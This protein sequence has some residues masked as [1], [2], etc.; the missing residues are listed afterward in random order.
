MLDMIANRKHHGTKLMS[1][2]S[3]AWRVSFGDSRPDIQ[4]VLG[5]LYG[6]VEKKRPTL[7]LT[8]ILY[9]RTLF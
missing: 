8:S 1:D 3:D 2:A 5:D 9:G 6:S 7:G 4:T